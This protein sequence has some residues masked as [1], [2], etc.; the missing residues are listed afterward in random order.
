LPHGHVVGEF[1]VQGAHPADHRQLA[2]AVESDDLIVGVHA[3][4]GPARASHLDARADE[5]GERALEL[6]LYG[7]EAGL[8]LPT[9]EVRTVV[10]D[11]EPYPEHAGTAQNAKPRP[12][13]QPQPLTG[14]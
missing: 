5:L 6:T 9:G 4:V 13:A 14:S 7:A 8:A 3:G 12:T 2:R 1:A 11:A 10:G